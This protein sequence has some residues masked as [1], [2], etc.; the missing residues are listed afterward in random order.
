[1]RRPWTRARRLGP[2]FNF[3]AGPVRPPRVAWLLLLAGLAVAAVSVLD[4]WAARQSLQART[5]Q[6]LGLQAAVPAAA[7]AAGA[8]RTASATAAAE[9]VAQAGARNAAWVV[10]RG[11][12]HPWP[13]VFEGIDALAPAGV[14]WL[15]LQH[16]SSRAELRLQGK[17]RSTAAALALV[18][19]LARQPLYRAVVMTQ[20][21][22]SDS[23]LDGP[24]VRF[25]LNAG[26][27]LVAGAAPSAADAAAPAAAKGAP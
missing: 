7:A 9:R 27:A 2:T 4:F 14:R 8:Q 19:R 1:M 13:L 23:G 11:L 16:D 15:A 10:A 24:G 3:V 12:Q 22:P 18:D 26:L 25:E 6:L 20:L 5:T 21:D 17:A